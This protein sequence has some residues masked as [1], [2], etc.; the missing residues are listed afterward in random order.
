MPHVLLP[1]PFGVRVEAAV[2]HL[3]V[4]DVLLTGVLIAPHLHLPEERLFVARALV[5]VMIAHERFV[6]QGHFATEVAPFP[7]A[8]RHLV[9]GDTFLHEGVATRAFHAQ[10]SCGGGQQRFHV[11]Q[12]NLHG[13]LVIPQQHPFVLEQGSVEA[14]ERAAVPG[15][16]AHAIIAEARTL[17]ARGH[18]ARRAEKGHGAVGPCVRVLDLKRRR[19]P[20]AL[21]GQ[22]VRN[23][24]GLEM[25][26]QL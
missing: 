8:M 15:V 18:M 23:E 14:I 12:A 24:D 4:T 19:T 20:G 22:Q 9:A 16:H 17:P 5:T 6:L 1:A 26:Q 7:P 10:R 11:R 25:V 13:Q 21:D 3:V 2:V